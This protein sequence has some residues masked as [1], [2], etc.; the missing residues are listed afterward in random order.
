MAAFPYYR[1]YITD[2][3]E[4]M[5]SIAEKPENM[6]LYY[7]VTEYHHSLTTCSHVPQYIRFKNAFEVASVDKKIIDS[8]DFLDFMAWWFSLNK[9]RDI[10]SNSDFGVVQH[11]RGRLT[12]EEADYIDHQRATWYGGIP[13]REL[14]FDVIE[15]FPTRNTI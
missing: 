10:Y 3:P 2:K 4:Q 11:F 15:H 9:T 7:F 6:R 13:L 8:R 5:L 1:D 12:Q 14:I